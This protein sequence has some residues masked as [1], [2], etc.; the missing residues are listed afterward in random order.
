MIYGGEGVV[1]LSQSF[2]LAGAN[3]LSVSLWQVSDQSTKLFMEG[4]Y[5]LVKDKG[6]G[7][8]AA[9]SFMKRAFIH[10]GDH[11]KAKDAPGVI[12]FEN[13]NT[14]PLKHPYYWA[15]FVF[16]GMN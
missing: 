2:L 1:G 5:R 10:Y 3:G 4:V 11:A 6:L 8:S 13:G 7:Y 9:I 16:Y 14:K 12:N 15:P